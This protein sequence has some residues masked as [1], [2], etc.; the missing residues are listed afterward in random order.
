[1]DPLSAL[2]LAANVAQFISFTTDL[3]SV[4]KELHKSASGSTDRI[5]TL[6]AT[7]DKLKRLSNELKS[8]PRAF[9]PQE[10]A[11]HVDAIN[12]ISCSCKVDCDS[13]LEVVR[14][15]KGEEHRRSRWRSFK[16]A[17]KT[18]WRDSEISA[19]EQRLHRTQTTLTLEICAM[20][21]Y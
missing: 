2:G 9:Q 7:Y 14:K 3:I 5:L 12:G 16:I 11:K 6:E 20:I 4:S 1:M 18:V 8:S 10:V 17:L 13:R 19:L 15:L 21:R